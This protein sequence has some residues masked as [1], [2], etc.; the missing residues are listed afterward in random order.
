M[1][2][3]FV[4]VCWAPFIP[5]SAYCVSV[6]WAPVHPHVRILC[7]LCFRVLGRYAVPPLPAPVVRAMRSFY[8]EQQTAADSARA[9]TPAAA[10]GRA[11]AGGAGAASAG[12]PPPVS[13][14]PP[15]HP[16][17]PTDAPKCPYAHAH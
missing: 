14:L 15:G 3:Y 4:F 6:C 12:S 9:A 7:I 10:A 11:G 16:S 17:V 8:T 2:A 13:A 5:M 1:S